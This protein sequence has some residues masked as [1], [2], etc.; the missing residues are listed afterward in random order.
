M[1]LLLLA[2]SV[3]VAA[4]DGAT[5]C[6]RCAAEVLGSGRTWCVWLSF[7]R[8]TLCAGRVF[9]CERVVDIICEWKVAFGRCW[10]VL[11]FE[12]DEIA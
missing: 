7:I 3:A 5:A 6:V 10:V 8:L 12:C 1:L 9:F 2:A 4:A 11:G